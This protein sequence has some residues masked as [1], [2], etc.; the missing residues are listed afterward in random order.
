VPAVPE[1]SVPLVMV[2]GWAAVGATVNETTADLLRTGLD[3]SFT[4]AVM[5]KLP[6]VVGVPEIN[7]VLAARLSPMGK[8]PVAIDQ[9]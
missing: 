6:L 1:G 4:A 8:L 2:S 9:V 3:E 5:G 7:P